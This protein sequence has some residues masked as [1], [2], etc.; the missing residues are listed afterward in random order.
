MVRDS[1]ETETLAQLYLDQGHPERAAPIFESIL[2]EDP[3][4]LS[5][6]E[7]LAQCRA[8]I[9]ARAAEG[10]MDL[11]KKLKFLQSLLSRLTGGAL[12]DDRVVPRSPP[13]VVTKDI[14]SAQ[15]PEQ[16]IVEELVASPPPKKPADP[17]E[18][19]LQLLQA[20]L[21]RLLEA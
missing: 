13:A 14:T 18:K 3:G 11:E 17:R 10:G 2:V 7:G 8:A 9:E 21:H 16:P 5:A 1:M 12:P 15:V 20:M 6:A 4:R 19:K